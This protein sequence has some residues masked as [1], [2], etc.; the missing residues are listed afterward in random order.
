MP[1]ADLLDLQDV[2]HLVEVVGVD[3]LEAAQQGRLGAP[4]GL[5]LVARHQEGVGV[6]LGEITVAVAAE[7]DEVEAPVVIRHVQFED[8]PVAV[9]HPQFQ[10]GIDVQSLGRAEP[11]LQELGVGV[12]EAVAHGEDHVM[13]LGVAEGS[14]VAA[15]HDGEEAGH[16]DPPGTQ[17]RHRSCLS[18]VE[19]TTPKGNPRRLAELTDRNDLAR[20]GGH[21]VTPS[22]LL[23]FLTATD[24]L[25]LADA[26]TVAAIAA[27]LQTRSLA[28]GEVLFAEGDPAGS[29]FFVHTGELEIHRRGDEGQDVLLRL[30]G[31]GEV[32][33]LT[34]MAL[35]RPRSATLSARAASTVLMIGSERFLALM[36]AHDDLARSVVAFLGGKVRDKTRQLT[37][38]LAR[39][40]ADP[41]ARVAVFDTKPYDR[42]WLESEAGDDLGFDFF[43]ARLGPGTARLAAGYRHV[44][45]FVN[46]DLSAPVLRQLA[47]GG[48]QLVALRCAGFNNVDLGAA[49]DLGITVVRVPAYSPHAVA[50]HAAA[51]LLTL[52]RKVHRAHQRVREGNFSLAGLEGFDLHGRTAG[53]IGL[54][55]IGRCLA[56]ILRG[57][58]MTVLGHDASPDAT[59]AARSGVRYTDLDEL[60]EQSDVISLHAPLVPGTHHL[61]NAARIARMKRGVLVIN[62]SRG[63]LIDTA[64]LIDGLKTGRIGGAGLDVYEEESEYFFED[65]SAQVITD[66]V[67]A[68][69]LTFPNVLVTSHQAFLTS[70]AL[71]AIAATTA[72]NVRE[73]VA[74]RR[75]DELA[76]RVAPPA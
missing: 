49:G 73:Y 34:S 28:A 51:L 31:P 16:G 7:V 47:A 52:N 59:Y 25:R 55:K 60:L 74:G 12:L 64:A 65:R 45:A 72:G 10:P 46:D 63:A 75:G 6:V 39:D 27:D 66:D 71:Q 56:D 54:G 76:N 26:S 38:L 41:R 1:T 18:N 57:F 70:D 11:E 19:T 5:L 69:L 43:E 58:G 33:G 4:L 29:V 61:I 21:V 30:M 22:K 42:Q 3:R 8:D 48:V 15:E 24:L 14:A 9:D 17:F 2:V 20:K 44:C 13:E 67:L 68:R 62:T 36:T 35:A 32:G 40:V 53:V 37:T 23:P 50:E